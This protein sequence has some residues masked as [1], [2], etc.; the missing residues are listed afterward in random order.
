[1]SLM[2]NLNCEPQVPFTAHVS[3]QLT[4]Y[5]V[6][7][8]SAPTPAAQEIAPKTPSQRS[9]AME[10]IALARENNIYEGPDP[11]KTGPPIRKLVD[12]VGQWGMVEDRGRAVYD[13][14]SEDPPCLDFQ[15]MDHSLWNVLAEPYHKKAVLL[16][17]VARPV[18]EALD[19]LASAN[20][21]HTGQLYLLRDHSGGVDKD[22]YQSEQHSLVRYRLR[23]SSGEIKGLG[24]RMRHE[25]ILFTYLSNDPSDAGRYQQTS[26]IIHWMQGACGLARLG[27]LAIF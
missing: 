26:Y 22:R 11:V 24:D 10:R 12:V 1:M 23:L 16:K 9:P 15:W 6:M 19:L 5:S 7:V 2:R 18:L 14:L 25:E 17:A 20:A 4:D 3:A 13:K 27:L 21:M 8:I